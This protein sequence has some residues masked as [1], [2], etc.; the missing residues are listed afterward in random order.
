MSEIMLVP[1]PRLVTVSIARRVTHL[2]VDVGGLQWNL[3]SAFLSDLRSF[4]A[5]D[6]FLDLPDLDV[7]FSVVWLRSTHV[8]GR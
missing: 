4:E 6:Q 5:F 1:L 8:C 7:L 2:L 3:K